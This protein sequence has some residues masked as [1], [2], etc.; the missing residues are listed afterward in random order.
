[1]EQFNVNEANAISQFNAGLQDSRDRFNASNA[2]I[3]E[4]ANAQWFQ[5]IATTDNATI[6]QANRDRFLTDAAMTTNGYNAFMQSARDTMNFAFNSGQNNADRATAI[7]VEVMRLEAAV[8]AAQENRSASK[9]A[10]LFSALGSVA[11]KV[12]SSDQFLD[13]VF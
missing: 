5:S 6:N 8:E 9:S 13:F 10:G 11:G 12:L 2:L 1:M 7:A 4:Q 3:I